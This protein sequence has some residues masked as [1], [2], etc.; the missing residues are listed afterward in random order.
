MAQQELE[1]GL[2]SHASPA[3]PSEQILY[4][5]GNGFD[6]H[7][8]VQSSYTAFGRHL[9]E[10]DADTYDQL[11]RYFSVDDDF[12]WQFEAQLA[13]LDTDSLLDE[14]AAY[15]P[16]YGS[17][18]WS[19]AGHHD[20]EYELDRVVAAIS[21]TL[22]LRFSEWVRQLVIPPPTLMISK[23]LP[24]CRDACYLTFNYTDTLQRVYG[25]RDASVNHIH[26]AAARTN[27]QL[28][29]GHGWER[30]AADSFN[31]RIDPESA[32]VR[33]MGGNEI[34]DRYFTKTFKPTARVIETNQPFFRSL[35]A[36]KKI[37]IMGHSLSAV[38]R[39]YLME[40]LRH[41]GPYDVQWQVSYHGSSENAKASMASMDI[42]ANQVNFVP[43]TEP[44]RWVYQ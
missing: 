32:D 18:D 40:L 1:Q 21:S 29:L 9:K 6:L 12:W 35:S 25:I 17:D 20:Y 10:V 34:I 24:L 15:L 4:I 31:H 14:A 26:G 33:V 30:T 5:V 8:G 28:V 42:D 22:R 23:L 44:A 41:L 13:H 39:P 2:S 7:H 38:D 3:T 36:I 19:E 27:D 43:L 11:E 37:F 16:S